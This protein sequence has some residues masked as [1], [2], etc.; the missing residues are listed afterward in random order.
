MWRDPVADGS[1]S[2]CIVNIPPS[3]FMV[4]GND[5]SLN[6]LVCYSCSYM[7]TYALTIFVF[8][9]KKMHPS[10][11]FLSVGY[12]RELMIIVFSLAILSQWTLHC[13]V[14]A[15]RV[16]C[17]PPANNHSLTTTAIWGIIPVRQ[18]PFFL[19]NGWIIRSSSERFFQRGKYIW[20]I[21]NICCPHIKGQFQL[22]L[23]CHDVMLPVATFAQLKL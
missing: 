3:L 5:L 13:T 9:H 1:Y 17:F 20:T 18:P 4:S 15:V 14:T 6:K 16:I 11:C 7:Y 8:E 12:S 19:V 2:G 21:V 10:N 22:P 23:R